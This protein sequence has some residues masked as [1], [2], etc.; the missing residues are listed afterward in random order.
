MVAAHSAEQEHVMRVVEIIERD[1]LQGLDMHFDEICAPEFEWRP[2][3]VGTGTEAYVGREGYRRYL[4]E[5]LTSVTDVSLRVEEVRGAAGGRA[6][7]LGQLT[8]AA[9]GEPNPIE[10]E[11]ALLCE[12]R[13]GR[14]VAAT[15]FASHASAVEAAD[16]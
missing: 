3:M 7:V 11:Y 9:R 5:L 13:G 8:I 12:V 14:L 16:A 4:E 15:A 1:G 6:L 2:T 10:T